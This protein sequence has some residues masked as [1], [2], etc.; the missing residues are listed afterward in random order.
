M[1]KIILIAFV[2]LGLNSK[3]QTLEHTFPHLV[4]IFQVGSTEFVY[5]NFTPSTKTLKIYNS[6]YNLI[7]TIVANTTDSIMGGGFH[8]SRTLF[9]NDNNFEFVIYGPSK[10]YVI[11]ENG[12]IL[13]T[14]NTGS[15]YGAIPSVKNTANGTKMLV[16]IYSNNVISGHEVYSLSGTLL[17]TANV[18]EQE[19][20]LP[21]PNP[22]SQFIFLPIND[23]N[24]LVQVY[25]ITG[26]MVDEFTANNNHSY[27]TGNLP[28]G[29]Y[30]Y[31]LNGS[32]GGR[33]LKE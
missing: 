13:F 15:Q 20:A 8:I 25:S 24:A 33:F 29:E 31:K 21:Y 30:F 7:K 12:N 9:N 27:N 14:K 6:D 4:N 19:Q 2:L 22:S 32:F 10:F 16:P 18:Q 26:A 5:T 11:G 3:A 1:K 23:A 28:V 17:R